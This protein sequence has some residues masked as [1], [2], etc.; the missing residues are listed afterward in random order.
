MD[1]NPIHT[2]IMNQSFTR[3]Y[4]GYIL[5]E[6]FGIDKRKLH[7]STLI[8]NNVLSRE[9]ALKDLSKIPYPDQFSLDEDI[10]YF[11]KNELV[12]R[13]TFRLFKESKGRAR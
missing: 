11:L 7:L 6:K 4:Q 2:N 1:T 5:P 3:F 8:L 10:E 13:R 9:E 12:S